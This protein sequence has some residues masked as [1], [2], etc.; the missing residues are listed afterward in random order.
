FLFTVVVFMLFQLSFDLYGQTT[1]VRLNDFAFEVPSS[2]LRERKEIPGFWLST[3][4]E[5]MEFLYRTVKKGQVEIIGTSA[6][7]RPIYAVVYGRGRRGK[8][9]TTF[10]GSVGFGSVKAYRGC[11]HEKIVY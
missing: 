4:D 7:G 8:G 10:S 6:G 9:T 1:M 3:V 5:V 2:Y 11:D